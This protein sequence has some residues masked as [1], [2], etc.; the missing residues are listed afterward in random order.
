MKKYFYLIILYQK[1]INILIFRS[2]EQA[3]L[4]Y[5]VCSTEQVDI[6]MVLQAGLP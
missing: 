3:R 2:I 4:G 1:I 5:P 6:G